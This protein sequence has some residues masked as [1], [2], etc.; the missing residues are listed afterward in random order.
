MKL[1]FRKK[2]RLEREREPFHQSISK[3]NVKLHE[4]LISKA[5]F[6]LRLGCCRSC[7]R[8][9]RKRKEKLNLF[10]DY[11]VASRLLL[12]SFVTFCYFGVSAQKISGSGSLEPVILFCCFVVVRTPSNY[13]FRFLGFCFV[14]RKRY[15]IDLVSVLKM[16]LRRS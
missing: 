11:S 10:L 6:S 4:N 15:K 2:L 14:L 1:F 8:E 9:R 13:C 12:W 7:G 3:K 16:F 5:C